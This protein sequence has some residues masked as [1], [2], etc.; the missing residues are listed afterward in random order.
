ML[1]VCVQDSFEPKC[2]LN[3]L[4]LCSLAT[5]LR[6]WLYQ[7]KT[8]VASQLTS[9]LYKVSNTSRSCCMVYDTCNYCAQGGIL[10]TTTEYRATCSLDPRHN[11]GQIKHA[12]HTKQNTKKYQV[13]VT[14][15]ELHTWA[16]DV[17][18]YCKSSL[19]F[20]QLAPLCLQATHIQ[21]A[22]CSNVIIVS[23]WRALSINLSHQAYGWQRTT[24]AHYR[25]WAPWHN[26][27]HVA[28]PLVLL[29][30]FDWEQL[31]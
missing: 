12:G 25:H 2:T 13:Y 3:Q 9:T 17:I 26:T 8:M 4:V 6:D 24:T 15:T 1:N 5:P 18:N 29:S 27:R 7:C 28:S 20:T 11:P 22:F 21:Q 16:S 19:W 10:I 14:P 23:E 30:R 31:A